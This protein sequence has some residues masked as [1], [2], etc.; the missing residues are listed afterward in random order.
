MIRTLFALGLLA[1]ATVPTLAADSSTFAILAYSDDS[2]YFAYEEFSIGDEG[3]P[4]HASVGIV[5]LTTGGHV[6]GSPWFAGDNEDATLTDLRLDVLNR[7]SLAMGTAGVGTY[8]HFLALNGD[9]ERGTGGSLTFALPQGAD[10]DAL[11]PDYTLNVLLLPQLADDRCSADYG[12]GAVGF[13]IMLTG[14][15]DSREI[16][17]QDAAAG[18]EECLRQVRLYGVIQPYNGGDL[19]TLVAIVSLYTVGF[20]GYDRRFMVIP[21]AAG[22]QTP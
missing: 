3:T 22:Q 2:R 20:E 6:D 17:R 12:G 21:V 7:S 11:G 19:E 15:G 16:Y 4:P 9:G 18:A 10:P 8:G 14:P 1:A 5:D 13:A